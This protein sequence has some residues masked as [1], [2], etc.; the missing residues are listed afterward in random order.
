L[1]DDES[2]TRR[3]RYFA[4]QSSS[5]SNKLPTFFCNSL[6]PEVIL[7]HLQST[8]QLL[9]GTSLDAE[10]IPCSTDIASPSQESVAGI[11][12]FLLVHG[13]RARQTQQQYY[14]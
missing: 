14:S 6:D 2:G 3:C 10:N 1:D 9:D 5:V 7:S 8:Y 12:L 4:I 11:A 13:A